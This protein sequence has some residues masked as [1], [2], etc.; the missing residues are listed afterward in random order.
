ML[1]TLF[2][3]RSSCANHNT[4]GS[5]SLSSS[6]K[7]H[8]QHENSIFLHFFWAEK[9]HEWNHWYSIMR[10]SEQV[11]TCIQKYRLKMKNIH[12]KLEYS[13][14]KRWDKP[15][16]THTYSI[17]DHS[18]QSKRFLLTIFIRDIC[19]TKWDSVLRDRRNVERNRQPTNVFISLREKKSFVLF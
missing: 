13:S 3:L 16:H 9:T 6:T 12:T 14:I 15:I 18:N 19:Q 4:T 11:L 7:K 10:S 8:L 17:C 2:M 5:S 1:W